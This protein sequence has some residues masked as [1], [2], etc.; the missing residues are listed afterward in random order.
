MDRLGRLVG[1]TGFARVN[2]FAWL[3]LVVTGVHQVFWYRPAASEAWQDI[4]ELSG[5]YSFAHFMRDVHVGSSVLC[6]VLLAIW[7]LSLLGGRSAPAILAS[8]VALVGFGLTFR[9]G[10]AI[11]WDQLAL[12]AVTVGTNMTG[13]VPVA[14]D[15]VRF[16]LVDGV[17]V[18]RGTILTLLVLHAVVLP[19]LLAVSVSATRR[20]AKGRPSVSAI[21]TTLEHNISGG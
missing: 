20:I 16:V 9:L 11:A 10:S 19:I 7:V 8:V 13:Y 15:E 12:W 4:S 17:E 2:L 1:G 3:L 5:S 6:G 14:N 21:E 18:S